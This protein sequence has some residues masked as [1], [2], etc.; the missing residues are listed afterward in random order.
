MAVQTFYVEYKNEH[1]E[2]EPLG[3]MTMQSAIEWAW[4]NDHATL[5][6]CTLNDTPKA[7]K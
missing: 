5:E 7:K 2:L 3:V 1:G 6:F 4:Q